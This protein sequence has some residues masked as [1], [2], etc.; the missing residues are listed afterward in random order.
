MQIKKSFKNILSLGL[1]FSFT[2]VFSFGVINNNAVLA[3]NTKKEDVLNL[4]GIGSINLNLIYEK[5][6]KRKNEYNK[7][8]LETTN[9]YNSLKDTLKTV[10]SEW[11][12]ETEKLTILEKQL[13]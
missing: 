8:E 1:I 11:E 10:Y 3:E 5:L 12:Q 4:K 2:F 6:E 9:E 13:N 7:K